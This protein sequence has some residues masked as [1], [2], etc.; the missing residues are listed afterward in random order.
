MIAADAI[1]LFEPVLV[2]DVLS[3]EACAALVAEMVARPPEPTPVLR[4][5]YD[6]YEPDVRFSESCYPAGPMR[7]HAL[8]CVERAAL[9]HWPAPEGDRGVISAPHFFRYP[10]GGFVRPHRDRSPN[11]DDPREVRWRKASLVL[12]LNSSDA[13]DGF[14]GGALVVYVSQVAG[15]TVAHT[16][17]AKAGTLA[18]FDPGLVHEVTRVREGVRFTL[19][20]W[21]IDQDPSDP[22]RLH[23]QHPRRNQ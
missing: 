18:M 15:P 6:R 19:V 5:G 10:K 8:S 12:F 16:I 21:L 20:A 4:A 23:D 13:Q 22:R 17:H 2:T 3:K 11:N 7:T 14:D 1:T 9:L